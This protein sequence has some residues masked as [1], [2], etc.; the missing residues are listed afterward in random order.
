MRT[1]L[2]PLFPLLACAAMMAACAWMMRGH[3]RP[4]H[5]DEAA[6]ARMAALEEEVASLRAERLLRETEDRRG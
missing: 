1:W 4:A 6:S 5:Q 3:T 2:L